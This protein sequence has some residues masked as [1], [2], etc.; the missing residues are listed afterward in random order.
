MDSSRPDRSVAHSG[1]IDMRLSD[2]DLRVRYQPMVL[3]ARAWTLIACGTVV[4]VI[5]VQTAA[6][7]QAQVPSEPNRSLV[8]KYRIPS[9]S[10]PI[11]SAEQLTHLLQEKIKYIFVLY[12]ENRSF[13]SY[14]GTFPG[15]DG[16]FSRPGKS[17]PGFYQP[18]RNSDGTTGEIHPFRIGPQ[19]QLPNCAETS[20]ENCK[21]YASDT[22]D[23]DHSHPGIVA[24]MDIVRGTA[25][26]DRFAL[27]EEQEHSQSGHPSLVARQYG[28]LTMAY[29]D[30]DTIPL[31]WRYA[32]R[33]T[34][35]DR[36]FQEM[37][38]PSTL[39]NISIIAAQTGQTQW[40]LHPDE[41]AW[42]AAAWGE[43]AGRAGLE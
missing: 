42:N 7:A 2:A 12:Q 32:S 28:E 16:L 4:A 9:S 11:L 19:D 37:T 20:A 24:K 34:L 43:R 21:L 31:L 14:F 22:D 13:D 30:C 3:M 39:G 17:T 6:S 5:A 15:A 41:F 33:F 40:A 23:L 36:V 26:M 35:F 27:T 25:Q 18:L 8:A 29:E 10:E 38:G 1:G